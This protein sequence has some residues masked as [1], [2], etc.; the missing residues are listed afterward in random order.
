MA[1]VEASSLVNVKIYYFISNIITQASLT[2]PGFFFNAR[3]DHY[4]EQPHKEIFYLKPE[5]II[6]HLQKHTF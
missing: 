1:L 3:K 2:K 6:P 4:I 5:Q